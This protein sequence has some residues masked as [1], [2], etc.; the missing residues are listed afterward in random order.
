MGHWPLSAR[1]RQRRVGAAHRIDATNRV[2][3]SAPAVSG[4]IVNK[5][6]GITLPPLAV[7]GQ[8]RPHQAAHRRARRTGARRPVGAGAGSRHSPTIPCIAALR[9]IKRANKEA[10]ANRISSLRI[11]VDPY[12]MFDVQIK[13]I[14]EYKRQLL[15]ILETIALYQA[16]RRGAGPG[17]DAA[18]QDFR[19]QSRRQLPARQADHQAR[20]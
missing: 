14:H 3:R 16:I 18:R 7:R 5:T 11:A 13:R 15:N 19:R 8:S 2:P 4:R 17:L 12:A 20:Q 10:L 1:T 9:A 6:N